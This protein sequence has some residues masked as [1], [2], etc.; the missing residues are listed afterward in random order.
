MNTASW[1][2]GIAPLLAFA[3]ADMFFGLKTGLIAALVFALIEAI[4]SWVSF[5]EL[6]QISLLSLILIV[7]FGALAWRQNKPILFKLQPSIISFFLS[8]WLLISWFNDEPLFV[9]MALKYAELLPIEVQSMLKHPLYLRL[10]ELV[11]LNTGIALLLHGIL[12]AWAAYKL[13]TWWWIA[14]RGVGFYLFCFIAFLFA[15]FVM[16]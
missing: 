6:D 16:L 14:I 2:L 1:L 11:T 8:L 7:I 13:S 9:A 15:R 12:T 5:G 3:I 10:L 4:W